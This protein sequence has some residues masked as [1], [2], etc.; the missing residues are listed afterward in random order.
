MW[1]LAGL[2]PGTSLIVQGRVKLK[3]I[4]PRVDLV[5]GYAQHSGLGMT[6][7]R[8][9]SSWNAVPGGPFARRCR[10]ASAQA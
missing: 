4:A 9:V 6:Y 1:G 3:D 7:S 2:E 10:I 5:R 8:P